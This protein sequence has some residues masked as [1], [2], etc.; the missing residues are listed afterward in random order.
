MTSRLVE[1]FAYLFVSV[2]DCAAQSRRAARICTLPHVRR[3]FALQ[4]AGVPALSMPERYSTDMAAGSAAARDDVLHPRA[5]LKFKRHRARLRVTDSRTSIDSDIEL[6]VSGT[7]VGVA[8]VPAAASSTIAR[9]GVR[10]AVRVQQKRDARKHTGSRTV[11]SESDGERRTLS[12]V[13]SLFVV[14]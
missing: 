5:T 2:G 9:P 11:P 7:E 14:R 8:V 1:T 10:S 12:I 3:T 13:I 6:Q 4:E